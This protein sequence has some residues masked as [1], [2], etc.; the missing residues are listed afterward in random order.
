MFIECPV[1]MYGKDCDQECPPCYNGGICHD[2]WGVCVCPAGFSG[3]N[4][5]IGKCE[6]LTFFS[7]SFCE[8]GPFPSSFKQLKTRKR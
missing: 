1:D 7:T 3:L 5:E 8:G 4:C 2:I 6:F